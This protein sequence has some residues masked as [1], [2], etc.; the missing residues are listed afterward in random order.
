MTRISIPTQV[1][2][3]RAAASLA[4][5]VLRG[6]LSG[7]SNNGMVSLADIDRTIDLI[8]RGTVEL[9][10][11]YAA[12]HQKS[13]QDAEQSLLAI[14]HAEIA[15]ER[16]NGQQ[17]S[18]AGMRSDPMHRL[19]ALPL[20]SMF[21]AVPPR[22]ERRFLSTYFTTLRYLIGPQFIS[23]DAE[24]KAIIQSLLAQHGKQLN[25]D[26]IYAEA[27][28]ISLMRRSFAV[29]S[30]KL[31]EKKG[32]DSWQAMMAQPDSNGDRL[33]PAQIAEVRESIS[34]F[35]RMVPASA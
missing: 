35:Q 29:L 30:R 19:L 8:E 3:G 9:D 24:C 12:T 28:T 7:L 15:E 21:D 4:L 16:E 5:K 11:A 26:L 33:T 10:R 18:R 1:A 31:G 27:R 20:E 32:L 25:W 6:V 2:A 23:F 17:K 14:A 13:V 34:T 22:F